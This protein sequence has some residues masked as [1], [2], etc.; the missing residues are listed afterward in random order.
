ML[1]L[2]LV[3]IS[4]VCII[5]SWCEVSGPDNTV[6]MSENPVL[7]FLFSGKRKSGKDYITDLLQQRLD[8]AQ[9]QTIRLSGPIKQQFA[10]TNC[11][12]YSQL[13]TAS[14]YKEKYRLEMIA[15]SESKRA[16]D[17]GFF[18][19]AAIDMYEGANYPIW[20][21]SDMRRQSDL[22]WFKQHYGECL[23]TVRI[24]ASEEVRK[25]R[26]WVFTPGIDDAE[27][28]CDLD[29]MTDW[30]QEVDNS[31]DPGKVD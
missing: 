22:S 14:E 10:K 3:I 28:E 18:I 13:L 27:S 1:S 2:P 15:W 24:T 25:Q 9:C 5:I 12:D 23:Y 29:N 21:V 6:I 11:L 7:I 20:I 19:R 17:I 30:D 8:D 26:G 16:E 4:V 31:N